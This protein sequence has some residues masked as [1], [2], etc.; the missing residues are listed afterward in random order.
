MITQKELARLKELEKNATHGPW[1]CEWCNAD[2]DLGI[3]A[4]ID[5]KS[6]TVVDGDFDLSKEDAQFIAESRNILPKLIESFETLRD[7]LEKITEED[8]YTT[9]KPG[10]YIFLVITLLQQDK[11]FRKRSGM[12]NEKRTML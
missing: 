2:P 3:I 4:Y 8:Q 7:A 10:I 12:R 9:N 1:S 11:L 5:S 6:S